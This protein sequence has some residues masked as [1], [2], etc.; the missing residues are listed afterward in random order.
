MMF[1]KIAYGF[2]ECCFIRLN[3][4]KWMGRIYKG[5]RGIKSPTSPRSMDTLL[6]P[7]LF[8]GRKN[9]EEEGR[10]N[11]KRR[12]KKKRRGGGRREGR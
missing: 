5:A 10:K 1:A 11:K 8:L 6:S 9:E 4:V 3:S 12:K 7:L 2:I